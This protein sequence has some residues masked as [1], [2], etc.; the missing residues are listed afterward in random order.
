[1]GTWKFTNSEEAG[2]VGLE[3]AITYDA[4]W[5]NIQ[6]NR[7]T[8]IHPLVQTNNETKFP[9]DAG[10]FMRKISSLDRQYVRLKENNV[11]VMHSFAQHC[12]PFSF[13]DGV[14][15]YYC[16]ALDGGKTLQFLLVIND[17]F[18]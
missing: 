18:Q 16:G 7:N 8:D 10:W 17:R 15:P 5:V 11:M 13:L 9:M 3:F 1:M 6:D 14:I 4:M 2:D 12:N